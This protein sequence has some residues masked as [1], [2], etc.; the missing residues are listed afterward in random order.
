MYDFQVA[1]DLIPWNTIATIHGN[2]SDI[3]TAL[4][5]LQS[6]EASV[7][8]SGYWMIDNHVVVQGGISEGAFFVVPF[9][10]QL[11]KQNLVVSRVETLNLLYEIAAGSTDFAN[12]LRYR[13][14]PDQ[15]A[16]SVPTV[17]A[18]R[19]AVGCEFETILVSL[20]ADDEEERRVARDLIALF[21]EHVY[22]LTILLRKVR[23]S[24]SNQQ[25]HAEINSLISELRN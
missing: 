6:S 2:C 18:V 16:A 12:T 11:C 25:F 8:T 4:S 5:L 9:L 3:P 15:T 24:T 1:L 14:Q 21:P 13:V 10:L 22:G 23:E 17:V 20:V 19:F 7:R